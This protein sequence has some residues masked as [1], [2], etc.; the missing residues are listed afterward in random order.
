MATA[1]EGIL[2]SVLRMLRKDMKC[3]DL[4]HGLLYSAFGSREY[5]TSNANM[6]EK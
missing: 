3:R 4:A 1:F 6:T 5:K 2:H